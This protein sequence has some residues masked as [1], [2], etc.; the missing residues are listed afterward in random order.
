MHIKP[1]DKSLEIFGKD[2]THIPP[3]KSCLAS[4]GYATETAKT[5][6]KTFISTN[7]QEFTGTLIYR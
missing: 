1:I 5:T 2:T 7:S 3:K 4:T 6:L